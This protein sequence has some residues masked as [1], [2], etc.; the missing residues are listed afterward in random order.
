MSYKDTLSPN[1]MQGDDTKKSCRASTH[2]PIMIFSDTSEHH[3]VT[4]TTSIPAR[5]PL[6]RIKTR[7][8]LGEIAYVFCLIPT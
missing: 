3:I 5:A 6:N 1:K 2:N 4:Y 8:A 7:L